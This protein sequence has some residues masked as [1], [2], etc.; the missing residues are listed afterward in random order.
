[1]HLNHAEVSGVQVATFP[2]SLGVLMTVVVDV[3][4]PNSYDVAVRAMRGQV[5][6]AERYP[7]PLEYRPPG[8]GVWLSAGTTT[9]VRVPIV[10]PIE[11]ALAL[12][13][14]AYAA[15]TI[16]YRLIGTAD[17]TGTRTLQIERDNYSVDE[18]GTIT[19]QQIEA[20][21]P[22]SFLPPR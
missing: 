13:R 1:M 9:S 17:V 15:P 6:M 20:I 12:L 7:L 4:N 21:L 10:M 3:Y 11:L 16:G 14:E 19:R 2:P 5:M 8:D 22:A 18:R